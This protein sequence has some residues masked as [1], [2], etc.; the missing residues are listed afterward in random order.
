MKDGVKP[1]LRVP[2]TA[3][4]WLGVVTNSSKANFDKY[5]ELGKQYQTMIS[6]IVEEFT[7]MGAVVILDLHWSDDVNEQQ[8][9]PLKA[10]SDT[11]GAVEFWDSVSA[12]F[13][14]ND[15][16][17]YELYNEPHNNATDLYLHGND[18]YTGMLDMIAAVRKNTQ[19]GVLVV[20]G[21]TGWAYDADSLIALE[22]QTTEELMMYNFHPYMGPNQAGDSKKSADGFE[23]MVK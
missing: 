2:M 9:M 7:G 20:A 13:K 15:H 14:D 6:K 3:S 4:Y 5:P 17:F 8:V 11:G 1:A 22:G 21:G 16:V 18:T 10:K 23:A 19:D 12:M